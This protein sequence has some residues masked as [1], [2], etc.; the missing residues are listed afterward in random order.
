MSEEERTGANQRLW[1]YLESTLS[2]G[3]TEVTRL[4]NGLNVSYWAL[5]ILSVIMFGVG[6]GLL[7]VPIYL[8]VRNPSGEE[9][10]ASGIT[11]GLG[12]VDLVALFLL[13]PI[14]RIQGL[15]GDMSQITLAINSYQT[16]VGLR[17]LQTDA[18]DRGTMGK[19]ADD[20][21]EASR[22]SIDLIQVY[23]EARKRAI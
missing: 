1:A 22:N 4:R 11:G 15:M 21:K 17:L 3:R 9:L 10:G 12:I 14:Q 23:F 16:Q 6:I 19:A 18:D 5:V 8:G 13:R 7:I 2:E 20:I